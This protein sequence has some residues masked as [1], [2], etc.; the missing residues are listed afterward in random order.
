M[1]TY[2]YYYTIFYFSVDSERSGDPIPVV[3]RSIQRA[4]S[5]G[6][7]F[8]II[9]TSGRLSNNFEL[10]EQLQVWESTCYDCNISS[11]LCF[12]E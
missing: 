6:F 9:D 11:D 4:K 10:I 3:T 12:R 5:E 2:F 8:V 7:D 1:N